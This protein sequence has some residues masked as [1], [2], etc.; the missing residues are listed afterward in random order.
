MLT[1]PISQGSDSPRYQCLH[2]LYLKEVTPPG[3]NAYMSYISRK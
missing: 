1:C 2:V 3:T